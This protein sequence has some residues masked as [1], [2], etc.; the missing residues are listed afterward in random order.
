MWSRITS[1]LMDAIAN[2]V[3]RLTGRDE[4]ETKIEQWKSDIF[5]LPADEAQRRAEALLKDPEKF[6]C[7]QA[8]ADR[9]DVLL[10][11]PPLLRHLFETYESIE[12]RSAETE[13][14]RKQIE[15]SQLAREYLKVGIDTAHT[16][17]AVKPPDETL[18]VFSDEFPAGDR[19]VETYPSIYHY[20]LFI[21]RL[22]S[23]I[24]GANS[25]E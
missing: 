25:V 22:T 4:F 10:S 6:T 21:D 23:G 20:L 5:A 14:R 17:L 9:E 18:F 19:L 13:L 24:E 16:E 8:P 15:W 2:S 1:R 3:S 12:G 7:I 11:L